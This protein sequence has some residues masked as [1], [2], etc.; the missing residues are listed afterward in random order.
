MTTTKTK[1][2]QTV[3]THC[4]ECCGGSYL[5][6]KNCAAG[7]NAEPYLQVRALAFPFG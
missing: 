1:L 7:S 6:V 5:D 2:L 3:R 4:L